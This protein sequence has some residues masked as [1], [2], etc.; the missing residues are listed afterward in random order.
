[1]KTYKEIKK[2]LKELEEQKNAFAHAPV[3][4]KIKEVVQ[5]VGHNDYYGTGTYELVRAY[6]TDEIALQ[7]VQKKIDALKK[8][9]VYKEGKASEEAK[10]EAKRKE[11]KRKRYQKELE[12]L[13]NRQVYLEKWLKENTEA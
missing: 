11:A 4:Y 12:E 8:M 10:A 1:M 3:G 6:G 5:T 2:E 9:K 7:K 13:K